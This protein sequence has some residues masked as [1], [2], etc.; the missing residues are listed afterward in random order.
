MVSKPG[1]ALA[2]SMAARSDPGP[3]SFVLLTTVEQAPVTATVNPQVAWIPDAS[4]AVQVT[5]VVPM[6]KIDPERGLQTTVRPGQLSLTV[7]GGG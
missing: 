1:L 5:V 2:Q 7:V 4:V 6:G 3:L